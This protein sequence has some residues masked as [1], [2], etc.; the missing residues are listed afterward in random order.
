MAKKKIKT[1]VE[2]EYIKT[3][4]NKKQKKQKKKSATKRRCLKEKHRKEGRGDEENTISHIPK[5]DQQELNGKT[6]V[7]VHILFLFF[8]IYFVS[9]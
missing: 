8:H 5:I 9:N 2:K 7:V 4:Q 3:K 1:E 6:D